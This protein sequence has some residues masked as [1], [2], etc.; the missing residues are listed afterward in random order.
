MV[1]MDLT[2]P[3]LPGETGGKR[4]F[5]MKAHLQKW[6]LLFANFLWIGFLLTPLLKKY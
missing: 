4:H 5:S 2:K 6:V 1:G 3:A